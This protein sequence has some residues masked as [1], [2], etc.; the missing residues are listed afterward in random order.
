MEAAKVTLN[1]RGDKSHC[2]ATA[3]RMLLWARTGSGKRAM[4]LLKSL[5]Q[6]NVMENLWDRHPPFQIDGSFGYTAGVGE[7]LLGGYDGVVR[8]L[9]AL[10][11][12]W[13]DGEFSGLVSRGGVVFDCRWQDGRITYL[14][15]T[16]RTDTVID[17]RLPKEMPQMNNFGELSLVAGERRIL[18]S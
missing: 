13:K 5:I 11:P 15:A 12:E 2:W 3:H 17:L 10:P 4:D 6:N 7:M 18:I 8:I 14:A 16:S 9:P 1:L